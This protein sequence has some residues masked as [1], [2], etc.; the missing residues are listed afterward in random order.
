[1]SERNFYPEVQAVRHIFSG[2]ISSGE[3]GKVVEKLALHLFKD[4][5]SEGIEDGRRDGFF[6][7][8]K[9]VRALREEVKN[10]EDKG[11]KKGFLECVDRAVKEM[12]AEMVKPRGIGNA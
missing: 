2:E 7:C 12:V 6:I 1:M 10:F 8:D 11:F 9:A 3:C 4:V 5:Y